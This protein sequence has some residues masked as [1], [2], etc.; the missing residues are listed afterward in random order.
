MPSVR[1][2]SGAEIAAL[3][4]P[5]LSE[6]AQRVR[7][8]DAYVADFVAG[9]YGRVELAA[10]E[11]RTLVRGRLQ[12]AARRR[13]LALRFPEVLIIF[14]GRPAGKQGREILRKIGLIL[15]ASKP[16]QNGAWAESV[17]ASLNHI[18]SFVVLTGEQDA[19][20]S[21]G[22]IYEKCRNHL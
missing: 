5:S 3:H 14:R 22:S 2:L 10:H 6:R 9:D 4:Q 21:L 15:A 13:G 12:A 1:K 11:R 19:Q 7:E 20:S 8:Y 17:Y 18:H 16:Q